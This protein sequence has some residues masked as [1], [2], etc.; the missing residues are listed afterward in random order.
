MRWVIL[1]TLNMKVVIPVEFVSR[2]ISRTMP[3]RFLTVLA[4]YSPKISKSYQFQARTWISTYSM[5]N[6]LRNGSL[7]SRNALFVEQASGERFPKSKVDWIDREM[8]LIRVRTV[9]TINN[10]TKKK[11]AIA[12]VKMRCLEIVTH[13]WETECPSKERLKSLI[14]KQPK[15]KCKIWSVWSR[16]CSKPSSEL[17]HKQWHSKV[18]S[19]V[20][21][22][23]LNDTSLVNSHLP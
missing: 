4:L 20:C 8:Y 22:I 7:R 12:K 18:L 16:T 1:K 5:K 14:Y 10:R 2:N 3:S 9:G 15:R 11:R 13:I 6:A 19:G 17:T 21:Q 23:Y